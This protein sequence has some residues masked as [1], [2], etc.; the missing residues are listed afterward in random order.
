M[1]RKAEEMSALQVNRLRVPGL[2][3]VGGVAGLALQIAPG[4]S[5]SWVLRAMVAGKRREMGLGGFPDVTLAAAREA[6]RLA[7]SKIKLGSDPIE[8]A[9]TTRA[10]LAASRAKQITLKACALDFIESQRKSWGEKSYDQWLSSL[11][12]HVFP[13]IGS[14]T[15][16][17]LDVSNV[18]AVLTPIWQ[19]K[20]ETASR[21]RGR[22]ERI[23]DYA[24]VGGLRAGENPARWKG[25]LALMLPAPSKIQDIEHFKAVPYAQ[26]AAFMAK[27]RG[28]QGQGAAALTFAI[29]TVARSGQARG[30]TWSE[31]DMGQAM[32]VI[33]KKRM[34]AKKEHRVPLSKPALEILKAQPRIV[35]TDLIFPSSKGTPLS[36]ATLLAVLKRMR[37]D[38]VPHGF[39]S[40]FKDW[41][42]ELTNY[43]REVSEMALAHA[44]G[45]KV[46]EAYRRGDLLSKRRLLMEDWAKFCS[47]QRL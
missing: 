17:D 9:R 41:C 44:V 16:G 30:A 25:H 38:A 15:V 45:D 42:S 40:T 7:R 20:T 46:E 33:S 23:L 34:K 11:E 31:I 4:G 43:P 3:S 14:L 8:D 19:N 47:A 5:R 21:V 35:G 22:I 26:M 27:L 28:Q 39:R 1:A 24:K 37:V 18:L 29:L 6:A 13:T 32:W 2:H 12:K 10:A 36:D